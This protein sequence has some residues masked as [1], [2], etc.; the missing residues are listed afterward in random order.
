MRRSARLLF[1]AAAGLAGLVAAGLGQPSEAAAPKDTVV[2][3]V[4]ENGKPAAGVDV[5]V[6]GEP[7]GG[8]EVE[9]GRASTGPDGRVSIQV[10]YRV[11]L[12]LHAEA[13]YQD[14]LY[15]S[16]EASFGAD[17]N[18]GVELAVQVFERAAAATLSDLSLG[19]SSH[20]LVEYTGDA[21][22]ITA[23]FD[24]VNGSKATFKTEEGLLFPLPQG[25]TEVK[26]VG[27]K[28]L[29]SND[30]GAVV[31]WPL[32]PGS[33]EVQFRFKLPHQDGHVD[34]VQPLPIRAGRIRLI[35]D[36]APELEVKGAQVLGQ[37][38]RE[39]QGRKLR[40]VELRPAEGTLRFTLEGV[41]YQRYVARWY[42]AGL[43][44]FLLLGGVALAITGRG[45]KTRDAARIAAVEQEKAALLAELEVLERERREGE[46]DDEAYAEDREAILENL[47][48]VLREL[49]ESEC[50]GPKDAAA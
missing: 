7:P 36:E 25:F 15:K 13:R 18:L 12:V 46:I 3:T 41:P 19:S 32:L 30:R 4:T 21:L 35:I 8:G 42:A 47:A 29:E 48:A 33:N 26:G 9:Y 38:T 34:Y 2:V 20:L 16:S 49:E 10:P 6:L 27:G 11:G 28:P 23:I 37:E 17:P 24:V 40:V 50:A 5:R 39:S 31:P 43:S 22:D 44:L 14:V 1:A 45:G